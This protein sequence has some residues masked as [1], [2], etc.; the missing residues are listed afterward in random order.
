MKK[1]VTTLS[2]VAALAL[3]ASS[4]LAANA[5][6]IS[7]AYGGG[8]G[9]T[10]YYI[11]DGVELFNSGGT[12]V[13]ISGWTLEY[14]S[15]TGNW[16]SSSSN[17]FTFPAGTVIKSCGYL[18]IQTGGASSNTAAIEF[19]VTPDF[20]TTG[21]SMSNSNGKVALFSAENANVACGSET[22]GT[23]VDKLAWG[24]GNCPEGT[25]IA[26]F[27]DQLT[28]AVRNNGGLDD[29]DDNSADFTLT[30]CASA[31]LNNSASATNPACGATPSMKG[32]WGAVK[33]IYR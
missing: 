28:M 14:G 10:S 15:A 18:L 30:A 27:P 33:S 5:V 3:L 11:Y 22:P 7:K 8:G 9:G 23:I 29:T 32:T 4:A 26:S 24:S 17:I 1:I 21:L 12:D 25:A 31:P 6:R 20:T 13:D 16:G 2:V 19:P